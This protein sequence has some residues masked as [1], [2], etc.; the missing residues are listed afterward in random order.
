[1]VCE[2]ILV[3]IRKHVI[4]YYCGQIMAGGNELAESS[5]GC[6]ERPEF[7]D[8]ES[9]FGVGAFEVGKV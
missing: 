5:P 8:E 9:V 2:L 4:A 1:M 6:S 7:L 3:G